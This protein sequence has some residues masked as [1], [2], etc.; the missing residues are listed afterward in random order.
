MGA[1]SGFVGRATELA[2]LVAALG[3]AIGGR[4]A[5]VLVAGEPGIG[6]TRLLEQLAHLAAARSVPVLWGRATREEGAP[7]FWPWR[8]ILRAWLGAVDPG[9]ARAL[10]ADRAA[11][12]ARIAPEVAGVAE[13]DPGAAAAVVDAE[14]RFALFDALSQFLVAAAAEG[15]LVVVLDDLHWADVASLRLLAHVVHHVRD[16]RLLVAGAFRPGDLAAHDGAAGLVAEVAAQPSTTRVDLAGLSAD[17]V[18]EQLA[19]VLGRP[20]DAEVLVRVTRRTGGNPLFVREVARLHAA[21]AGGVPAAVRTAISE[22]LH[23]LGSPCRTLLGTAAVISTDLDPALLAAVTGLDVGTTVG[24]L[25]EALDAGLVVRGRGTPGYRFAHDLVR[26]CCELD[27]ARLDRARV[28]LAVADELTG[29]AG[30]EHVAEVAHHRIAARPLGDP[31]LAADAAARS[32]ALA[33][34]QL[35]F[36]EA[37]RRYGWALDAATAAGADPRTRATLL[38][39]RAR[40]QHRANDNAAAMADCQEAAMLAQQVG[41]AE[42][43]GQVA[44][45]LEDTSEPEWSPTI[46]GWC[47]AALAGLGDGHRALRV[48]LLAQRAMTWVHAG[49]DGRMQQ[50]SADALR[51]AEQLDDPHALATALRARQLARSSPQGATERLA[52]AERMAMLGA[53]TGEPGAAMWG[54]LWRFDALVQLGRIDEA[55][56]E[57]DRLDA[58]VSR[59]RQPLAEW[60]LL[61]SRAAIH[62]GRGRFDQALAVT[63][64]ASALADRAG[65]VGAAFGELVV[66]LLVSWWSGTDLPEPPQPPAMAPSLGPA[67]AP[68]L[69]PA[70]DPPGWWAPVAEWHLAFGRRDEAARLYRRMPLR[71]QGQPVFVQFTMAAGRALVASGLGDR[72]G[73]ETAYD[74]L[75]PHADFFVSGGAGAVATHGSAQYHLGVAAAGS[76]RIDDAVD[77]LRA[78]VAANTAAGLPP[79]A[80]EAHCR[81]AEVLL[82]RGRPGDHEAA[83]VAASEAGTIAARIGMRLVT[84]RAQDVRARLEDGTDDPLSPRER[85]IAGLVAQGLTNR[86]IATRLHI[87]ERTAENHVQHI[88]TKLGFSTRSRI[89]AWVSARQRPPGP[90]GA[91]AG[92]PDA[93]RPTAQRPQK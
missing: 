82:H 90:A 32:A 57:L 61:R 84:A 11:E 74:E 24:R 9:T 68:A 75:L 88:L 77:H 50:A 43:L 70:Q 4:T 78:A 5:T 39:D 18:G 83:A 34:A 79:C 46:E 33:M 81:L 27:L 37:A 60:H 55:E 80:A 8:L 63:D 23:G 1:V 65:L 93:H 91:A 45:V 76:G 35:A 25:D 20:P 58:V 56:A 21:G 71:V 59:M 29:R 40:A 67:P 13:V 44:L 3:T 26:E 15:P 72:A 41:D 51:L 7:A 89:A 54:H 30:D 73:A 6:K 66:R 64:R 14:T 92:S 2:A 42:V 87:A 12:L 10:L 62:A 28:H 52:L 47:D 86:Q 48:R 69:G 36:E 31:A 16:A 22:R 17:E 85:Q 49:D 19:Q 53:R 38:L